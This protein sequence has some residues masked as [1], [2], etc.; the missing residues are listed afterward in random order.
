MNTSAGV[1]EGDAQ[2]QNAG[3]PRINAIA[4]QT[5]GCKGREGGA[6]LEVAEGSERDASERERGLNRAAGMGTA[7]AKG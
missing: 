1:G 5:S 6:R 3:K 2:R 7:R 4:N